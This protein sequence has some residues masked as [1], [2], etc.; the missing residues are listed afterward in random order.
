MVQN[1]WML[2]PILNLDGAIIICSEIYMENVITLYNMA[3]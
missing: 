2:D 1:S 3:A